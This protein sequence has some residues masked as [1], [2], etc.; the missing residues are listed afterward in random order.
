MSCVAALCAGCRTALT[1][2][3]AERW[4]PV[5]S[6]CVDL[7]TTLAR[8]EH[9]DKVV[10]CYFR[11]NAWRFCYCQKCKTTE[12][13]GRLIAIRGAKLINREGSTQLTTDSENDSER[14][15]WEQE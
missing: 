5:D 7:G 6:A 11:N 3:E 2:E 9:I 1:D 8:V 4:H 13:D 15:E 12:V 14:D 10:V